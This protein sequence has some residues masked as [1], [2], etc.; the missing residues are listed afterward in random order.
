[1]EKNIATIGKVLQQ[2][3]ISGRCDNCG[4]GYRHRD[5]EGLRKWCK[6]CIEVYQRKSSMS[7][8]A[9]ERLIIKLVGSVYSLA[10]FD[11]FKGK[12][13]A[14]REEL[15]SLG[16]DQDVFMYGSVGSGKTY[17]MAAL[18]RHFIYEG[19]DCQRINFDD[20]CVQVRSTFSQAA[21]QTEL[22]MIEPLKEIDKL[23][24][25]DLGLRANNESDF[26]YVTLYTIIEKRQS[27]G[28]PIYICSNKNIE[29]LCKTF[30]YRIA[31]RIGRKETKIIRLD[32]E[33]RRK[34][35]GSK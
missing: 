5:R 17:A 27:N 11:N 31:S 2:S 12:D 28:L 3:N 6:R 21:K 29:T 26:A 24:I 18:L 19:Y 14:L 20:F 22:D 23:F 34:K 25:D 30:D 4:L 9:K 32:G 7:V 10:N 33:D 16:Q 35:G 1:M 15:L 8:D 13:K